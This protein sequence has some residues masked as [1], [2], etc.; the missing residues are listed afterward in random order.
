MKKLLLS[1][2]VV[3]ALTAEAQE[4]TSEVVTL[5]TNTIVRI[6]P[7]QL[8]TQQLDMIIGAVQA[9]GIATNAPIDARGIDNIRVVRS[10]T[11]TFTVIVSL[12]PT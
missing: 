9:R 10:G 5:T 12:R 6:A 1:L 11:N 4:Q 8:T 7:V 3:A 2:I